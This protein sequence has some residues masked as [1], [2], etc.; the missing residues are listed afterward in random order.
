MSSIFGKFLD[1]PLGKDKF[2]FELYTRYCT[3]S[4]MNFQKFSGEGPVAYLGFQKEGDKFSLATSAHTKGRGGKPCFPIFYFFAKGGMAQCPLNTPLG[5]AHR[6][7]SPDSF[8]RSI[9]D[10][11]SLS[12]FDLKSR[13]V[14]ALVL[15]FT[16]NSPQFVW[17]FPPQQRGT[18]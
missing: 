1:L 8:P 6:A 4:S 17:S 16:L 3:V 5:G 2:S 9:L 14:H 18:R 13:A 11:A 12:G 10:W 15:G 7:L